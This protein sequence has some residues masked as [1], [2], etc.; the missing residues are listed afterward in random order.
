MKP[1]VTVD[2]NEAAARIAHLLSE[3]VAIYPITPASPMGE[4]AETWSHQGRRNLWGLVPE[5]VEMQS[6]AGAAGT[7]HG[8]L[9]AGALATTF[10][11]SQGLLLMIPD[12]YRIAG[13][14]T[15]AVI[16][17]AARTV[18]THALSI[19]CDHSDVMAVRATG[20]AMLASS[21]VQEAQDLAVVAH[22]A[23]LETRVPF[24]HFFDGFRTS[25]EVS[26]IELLEEDEVR[27]LVAEEAVRAH[28]ERALDSDRPVLRGSAQNPDVFFQAREAAN[29]YYLAVPAAVERAMARFAALTGRRYGL[30]EYAGA[31]DA[32]RVIVVIGSAAGACA[33][34]VERRVA[35]GEKVGVVTLRLYRPFPAAQLVACLPATTRAIAVLDRTKEP[36]SVGEPLYLDVMAALAESWPAGDRPG[37]ARAEE[38][39]REEPRQPQVY[40]GRYG[41]AS[42]EFTPAMAA[43]VLAEIARTQPKRHFTVGIF[44]DVTALSLRHDPDSMPEP[45]DVFRAVFFG[46]GSD[47]TV[48][49]SKNT[50]K[51]V[52]EATD[53]FA[54]GYSVYDSKKSGSIT[55]SHVRFAPRPIRSSYLVRSAQF[56]SCHQFRLL[57]RID[58]LG[59]AAPGATVLLN[60]AYPAAEVWERLPMEAQRQI[61]TKGLRL[62]VVDGS[63]VAR[64]AGLGPRINTVMQTCFFALTDLLP[65]DQALARVEASVRKSYGRRGGEVLARNL[66][67]VSSA[68]GS[69]AEVAVPAT[70]SGDGRR[71]PP[72]GAEASDFVQRVTA[73]MLAGEG[74]LLPVSALPVDGTF[75]LGTSRFERRSIADE[76][77]IWDPEICVACGLCALVCPHAA[78]RSKAFPEAALEGAPDGFASRPWAGRDLRVGDDAWRLVIQ[79]F[80]DDCTGCGVCV[81]VCPA[82]SKEVAGHKSLDLLPKEP[83]LERERSNE[84][85]YRSLP[86]VD[87]SAVRT[88]TVQG[89]QLLEPL[90]EASGACAGCGE[91]PYLKLL[92]QL[93]GDRIL[94]ANA[95][96]CSSIFGGNLP[97]TPWSTNA[98]GRGPAWANSLFEDNAEFGLGMRLALDQRAAQARHALCALRSEVGE[99]LADALLAAPQH[100]EAAIAAQRERVAELERRCAAVDTREARTLG[101][102]AGSLVRRSV[103]IVGGDGWA[104]DIGFGGVDHVLAS[105]RDVNLLVLDT[106]VYSN[107]GGQ[108]SKSTP[109]GAVAKFAASGKPGRK[110]DLGMIAMAYG[111]VYVAQVALGGNPLQT[112]RALEEAESY[113]GPSLVIAYSHC[114]AHGID[115]SKSMRH[116]RDAVTCGYWPLYR[117]DPTV[118]GAAA[119]PFHLD[120][121]R[122]KGRFQDFAMQETRFTQLG[123][124]NPDGARHLLE[125]AQDDID[126]RWH[127]YEQMQAVERSDPDLAEQATPCAVEPCT[128]EP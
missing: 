99:E 102:M 88:G 20:W 95:T 108:S 21:S 12:M 120:S 50:V 92:S 119:H 66:A 112:I 114:I 76:I 61:H 59:V 14:L 78:I 74:D 73:R 87:R 16:H 2:G 115:M 117:Y 4:L 82:K 22:A 56:V 113:P 51:I 24:L 8:A 29:P 35:A 84:A 124:A 34:A 46:L 67:A 37:D 52:G 110:K 93:F 40:G 17:V 72:F 107:T 64:E 39:G 48:G 42:K 31:P 60:S 79:V 128:V 111:N 101:D 70:L 69:L 96:G 63:R 127:L 116:Q 123:R 54:Q 41:L 91:T 3:V 81:E 83:H 32:E 26:K 33:E 106:E 65:L 18:A 98:E 105:G 57:E 103:W 44:D 126:E 9:Q 122:P 97:T 45:E 80:P 43:E 7:L 89:S 19:F 118:S 5:V 30:C 10:T 94:V 109:R 125:L 1:F 47:G 121:H 58:V 55:V 23:T 100:G 11:A 38:A 6:E 90:F 68:L 49:A 75:P 15:P 77:P 25:H 62:F 53:L 13:E 86:E 27:S 36:G 71:L 28:R 85:F 104:Y